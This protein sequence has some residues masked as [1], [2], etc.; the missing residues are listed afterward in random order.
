M[1]D[2]WPLK[3]SSVNGNVPE[4]NNDQH[5]VP[6]VKVVLFRKLITDAVALLPFARPI[7]V[8]LAGAL[9]PVVTILISLVVSYNWI[10][11]V[12]TGV[13]PQHS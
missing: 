9:I 5:S 7:V 4:L 1:P 10:S 2:L 12:A 13:D 11:P 3:L 8:L 6:V